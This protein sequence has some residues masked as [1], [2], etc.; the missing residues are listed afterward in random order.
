MRTIFAIAFFGALLF[1]SGCS[2][3]KYENNDTKGNI[4]RDLKWRSGSAGLLEGK[5]NVQLFFISQ[6]EWSLAEKNKEMNKVIE[7]EKWLV[8]QAN[9]YGKRVEFVNKTYGFENTILL[10]NI[11]EGNAKG[12]ENTSFLNQIIEHTEHKNKKKYL[13]NINKNK[14]YKNTLYLVICNFKGQGYS[15]P[16]STEMNKEQYFF[17]G[18]ILYNKYLDDQELCSASIAHEILHL[19]SAWD[20]YN[21]F[22]A[23]KDIQDKAQKLYPNDIMLR[24][25][26][27]ID[28]LIIDRLTAWRVGLINKNGAFEW[29]AP[30]YY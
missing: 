28:E 13:S 5:I 12:D 25:S 27:N 22:S 10:P 2:T 3:I 26:Y 11:P 9:K 15:L 16:Y 19:F 18:G 29:F 17:E 30:N 4:K 24:V 20:L 23:T 6:E 1:F 8:G 14:E 7:A 21:T